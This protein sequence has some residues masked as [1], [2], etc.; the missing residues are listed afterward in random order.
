[1]D[2]EKGVPFD[3]G[4]SQH[5]YVFSEH[6]ESIYNIMKSIKAPHQ[7]RFQFKVFQPKITS[8]FQN[9]AAFYLGCLLWATF[10]KQNFKDSPKEILDNHFYGREMKDEK[11]NF[12]EEVDFL[13][14]YCG[15]F[16]KD[17]KYYL[18][19]NEK[20]PSN[21]T[22]VLL[23]YKDFLTIN[24][25]FNAV[26]TTADL[27]LPAPIKELSKEDLEIV[28][29]TINSVTKSGRLEGLFGVEKLLID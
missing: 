10:I 2:F 3:P 7:K 1:M 23:L 6:I 26:K 15:Q 9:S 17:C 13:I 4:Y 22:R 29:K 27:K 20:L 19:K 28:Y 14:D 5:T 25:N 8:L 18:G 12:V 24:E 16:E 11:E 21:W